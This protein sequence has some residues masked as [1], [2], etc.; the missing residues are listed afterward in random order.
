[1]PKRFLIDITTSRH[2]VGRH[3]VG[4]VRTEREIAK[5]YLVNE[6]RAE[7]FYYDHV[8]GDFRSIGREKAYEILYENPSQVPK[9]LEPQSERRVQYGSKLNLKNGDVIVS[10]GLLWD[11]DYLSLLYSAKKQKDIFVSQIIYDI[12]PIIMPEYCVPGMDKKFP[13]FI[14]DAAWT[15]DILFCISDSTLRD[16]GSYIASLGTRQPVLTRMELGAD[17]HVSTPRRAESWRSL[18]SGRFVL[19]VSTIEPRKNHQMLF[20]IWRELHERSP[21]D[22]LPLIFVGRPGWNV[23]NLISCIQGCHR[24]YPS[25]IRVLEDVSDEDLSWL[26]ENARFTVYP[27]LYEGWGLPIAESLAAG[28]PCLASSSSSMPEVA[29]DIAEL[30]HPLDYAAWRDT[31][32]RYMV[33][34]EL[35]RVARARIA[36]SFK[37]RKWEQVIPQ[38]RRKLDAVLAERGF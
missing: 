7:F 3:A 10:A 12:I 15:A 20:N 18:G 27:S 6:V 38:F 19:Y 36:A 24:L 35:V 14:L 28:T 37:L 1:M 9:R 33:D 17:V 16:V 26:Y 25:H 11:F 13:K 5:D 8:N 22:I 4:I 30:L 21:D 32:H 2:Y 31:I 29:G 34:D 23:E